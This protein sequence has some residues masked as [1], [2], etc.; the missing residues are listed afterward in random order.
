MIGAFLERERLAKHGIA[1]WVDEHASHV[2]PQ[3]LPKGYCLPFT[4]VNGHNSPRRSKHSLYKRRIAECMP[5]SACGSR[6]RGGRGFRN[7]E[8]RRT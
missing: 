7:C 2:G 5:T 4:A 6:A 1:D 8:I 3:T